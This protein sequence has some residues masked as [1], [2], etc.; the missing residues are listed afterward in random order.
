MHALIE[1]EGEDRQKKK[2]KRKQRKT[3]S[4]LHRTEISIAT[5]PAGIQKGGKERTSASAQCTRTL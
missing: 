4:P 3:S 5:A 1:T 2:G